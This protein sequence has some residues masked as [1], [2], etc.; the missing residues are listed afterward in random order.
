MESEMISD[1]CPL[2]TI[3]VPVYNVE[4]Y[5]RQCLDSIVAQTYTNLEIL[6]IDDGSTDGSAAVVDEYAQRDSRIH[7]VHQPNAG[8]SA[9]RNTGLRLTTGQ[10]VTM[11]DSDD[12]IAPQF[13]EILQQTLARHDADIAVAAWTR[14]DD[15]PPTFKPDATPHDVYTSEQAINAVFYQQRLTNSACSRLFKTSLFA[16]VRFPDGMLYEDL[17]VAYPLLKN[18]RRIVYH[19][20]VAY[21]Y[22]R[23]AS[24]IL[25]QFTPERVH[26]LDILEHLESQVAGEAPQYLPAVRS[27]RLSACFN[28][29]L[30]CCDNPDQA[31]TA[32]RCWNGI[33]Q[34]RL[35]CLFDRRIRLK[36][37]AG[38]LVSLL[39]KWAV[40]LT[41][42]IKNPVSP[43]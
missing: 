27:R 19:H 28:I 33:R 40:K 5:L 2:V 21:Y 4:P 37:R 22:R 31:D 17:A 36:N 20:A 14:F 42:R 25:G 34:L 7:T 12:C 35:G 24:S 11:V 10:L 16:N 9:A 8:L 6:L 39:G 3:I 1:N 41:K 30:L 43:Q 32:R 18:A 38:I 15:T 13:V 29:Y 23:R 26:V